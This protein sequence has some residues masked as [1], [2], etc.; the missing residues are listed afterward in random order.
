M[1]RWPHLPQIVFAST[2]HDKFREVQS[3]LSSYGITVTFAKASLVE[4]Q[5]ESLEEIAAN[6]AKSA[7]EKVSR[8]VIVEDDG[9]FVDI[10][11]GFP[12]QYSSYVFRTIG[13]KGL[14]RL[15]DGSE[16][17]ARAASFVSAIAYSDGK[18]NIVFVGQS[19]GMIAMEPAGEGWGY[20]PVF[21]PENSSLTFGQLGARKSE[22][23]HRR[24]ALDKFAAWYCN[25]K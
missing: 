21:I 4:I 17:K 5:S 18:Q 15:L 7:F 6:K 25:R 10:L 20:D 13:N 22:F 14:L 11:G 12:G 1:I 23:S 2:N 9:L 8:Q 3:I 24:H 19:K 16:G